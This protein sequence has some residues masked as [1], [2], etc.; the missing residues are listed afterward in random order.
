[1]NHY[2][3]ELG[4]SILATRGPSVRL[5]EDPSQKISIE[6]RKLHSVLWLISS[7]STIFWLYPY[8]RKRLFRYILLMDSLVDSSPAGRSFMK[9]WWRQ[10]RELLAGNPFFKRFNR[11]DD[12]LSEGLSSS[13]GDNP[14]FRGSR[15]YG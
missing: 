14:Y 12:L 1:M 13:T 8:T 4:K 15:G 3:S 5:G 6:T 10:F 9:W 7:Y 11:T 2:G